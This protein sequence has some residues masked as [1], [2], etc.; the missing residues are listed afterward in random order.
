[1][2]E[3]FA[4]YFPSS[5]SPRIYLSVKIEDVRM[6]VPNIRAVALYTATQRMMAW[7]NNKRNLKVITCSNAG[8]EGMQQPETKGCREGCGPRKRRAP[9]GGAALPTTFSVVACSSL[10]FAGQI[11][12]AGGKNL[13]YCAVACNAVCHSCNRGVF[14]CTE[15]MPAS[16]VWFVFVYTCIYPVNPGPHVFDFDLT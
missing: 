11:Y 5:S 3:S 6:T 13:I 8:E 4:A 12:C 9:G 1:M 2:I 10:R 15:L 14:C 16:V 7:N